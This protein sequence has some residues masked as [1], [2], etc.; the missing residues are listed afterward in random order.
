MHQKR[1]RREEVSLRRDCRAYHAK[2]DR[3]CS[4][5]AQAFSNRTGKNN[6]DMSRIEEQ[7]QE[8]RKNG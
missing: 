4:R 3:L 1:K 6:R 7:K 8:M 2:Y 5:Y